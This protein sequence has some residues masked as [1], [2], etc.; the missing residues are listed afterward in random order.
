[1][2]NT[3]PRFLPEVKTR[4]IQAYDDIVSSHKKCHG[5]GIISISD[6]KSRLCGCKI[7]FRYVKELIK[8]NIPQDY[9]S[10]EFDNLHLDRLNYKIVKTYIENLDRAK[11]NGL[12]L[13]LF[14]QNGTGKTSIMAEIAKQA[15]INKYK[16]QY[17]TLSSYVD[18]LL[19]KD[20]ERVAYYESGDFLL[21]DELDKKVGT[22]AIYKIIDEFL[23]RM[24]NQGKSL[25]MATNWDSDELKEHLGESTNSLLKRRSEFLFFQ[26]DDYSETLQTKYAIRLK[27]NFNYFSLAIINYAFERDD[28]IIDSDKEAAN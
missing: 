19:S 26:G 1:M 10:L 8:A 14:G 4:I 23:R 13:V 5:T 25:I 27:K 2:K 12:G 18:A 7:V 9:W 15:I 3:S 22:A 24:F 16:A 17:F 11:Q 6:Y 20:T 21:I 28:Q